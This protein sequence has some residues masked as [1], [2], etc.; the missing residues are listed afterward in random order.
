M[1]ALLRGVTPIERNKIHK[2]AYLRGILEFTGLQSV[3]T[4]IQSGN[5]IC[6]TDLSDEKFNQLIHDTIKI[7]PNWCRLL[8]SNLL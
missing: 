3:Q 5:I 7:K 6:E 4:Y 1:R 2:M 8:R